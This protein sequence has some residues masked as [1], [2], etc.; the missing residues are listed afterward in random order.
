MRGAAGDQPTALEAV[1]G[2]DGER[3]RDVLLDEQHGHVLVA[4]RRPRLNE[5]A[6]VTPAET[7]P[8]GCD[9]GPSAPVSRRAHCGARAWSPSDDTKAMIFHSSPSVRR[10]FHDGMA[11]PGRP[12]T[13]VAQTYPRSR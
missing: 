2:G 7:R 3:R 5:R 8:P 6:P 10:P 4:M 9:S 12:V 11:E 1:G 13:S